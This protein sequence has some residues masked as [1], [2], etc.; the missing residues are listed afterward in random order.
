MVQPKISDFFSSSPSSRLPSQRPMKRQNTPSTAPPNSGTQ[1][2]QSNPF[3]QS[4]QHPQS[5]MPK[6]TR[7]P[8]RS[9]LPTSSQLPPRAASSLPSIPSTPIS[10]AKSSQASKKR[11]AED[12]NE[13]ICETPLRVHKRRVLSQDQHTPDRMS[14]LAQASS[15]CTPFDISSAENSDSDCEI[16]KVQPSPK[17]KRKLVADTSRARPTKKA[18]IEQQPPTQ[19]GYASIKASVLP[20]NAASAAKQKNKPVARQRQAASVPPRAPLPELTLSSLGPSRSNS[21]PPKHIPAQAKKPTQKD[22][23]PQQSTAPESD[24]ESD[25]FIEKVLPSPKRRRQLEQQK[26]NVKRRRVGDSFETS[27]SVDA[28]QADDQD[29]SDCELV[30]VLLSP[31]RQ[32]AAMPTASDSD[33]DDENSQPRPQPGRKIAI[34]RKPQPRS[35]SK[36]TTPATPVAARS[37]TPSRA[38]QSPQI[39][40]TQESSSD[41][42]DFS[43]DETTTAKS[44]APLPAPV[45]NVSGVQNDQALDAG[46][47]ANSN[48]NKP[49]PPPKKSPQTQ[50][51]PRS[52]SGDITDKLMAFLNDRSE[53]LEKEK[54]ASSPSSESNASSNGDVPFSTAPEYPY[55]DSAAKKIKLESHDDDMRFIKQ[56]SSLG[57]HNSDSDEYSG[58][59]ASVDGGMVPIKQESSSRYASS[60]DGDSEEASQDKDLKSI[61]LESGSSSRIPASV[62]HYEPAHDY[63]SEEEYQGLPDLSDD[64]VHI[65]EDKEPEDTDLLPGSKVASAPVA[66]NKHTEPITSTPVS[67]ES[68][69][70]DTEDFKS[71]PPISCQLLL[72]K[73]S[74]KASNSTS[75]DETENESVME[76][77]NDLPGSMKTHPASSVSN[78]Q[79]RLASSLYELQPVYSGERLVESHPHGTPPSFRPHHRES[80]IGLKSILKGSGSKP[81][82][83]SDEET[84]YSPFPDIS[85]LSGDEYII[86]SPSE[87]VQHRTG[88]PLD[89]TPSNDLRHR[90]QRDLN[91]SNKVEKEM[92]PL[93]S[94]IDDTTA[95]DAASNQGTPSKL[96]SKRPSPI[97]Q[98]SAKL[99]EQETSDT[100]ESEDELQ[101]RLEEKQLKPVTN[102]NWVKPPDKEIK[103]LLIRDGVS[104]HAIK[105]TVSRFEQKLAAGKG[106]N[107]N[108]LKYNWDIDWSMPAPL[109]ERASHAVASELRH[110]GI[111][112][113]KQYSNFNYNLMMKYSKLVGSPVPLFSAHKQGLEDF[114]EEAI[115]N[116]ELRKRNGHKKAL[117]AQKRKVKREK[118]NKQPQGVDAFLIP[119]DTD[120]ESK[121]EESDSDGEDLIAKMRADMEKQR[122]SSGGGTSCGSRRT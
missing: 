57:Q 111:K 59:D 75:D 17:P 120:E 104:E 5:T 102:S 70:D 45:Q 118:K 90:C 3:A 58:D 105:P 80:F 114:A 113:D 54:Q 110:R 1:H 38:M 64:E 92:T 60:S 65:F 74:S 37:P 95:D 13:R 31:K 93:K 106:V 15:P 46:R 115:R 83:D 100:E 117:K 98:K 86:S 55:D 39:D 23:T 84:V 87:R 48:T 10:G 35:T 62:K 91:G 2:M 78:F 44:Q 77:L 42:S 96:P 26:A 11:Q 30:K 68:S 19:C 56:E 6:S 9:G 20:A 71:S 85:P 101:K 97:A 14:Q 94:I 108:K 76:G 52:P 24:D 4:P 121:S 103:P 32:G 34:P 40:L 119:G 27:I 79:E 12:R 49:I 61:K 33:A 8:K 88:C 53:A 36:R 99:E 67:Y 72:D 81:G 41:S 47:P 112:T 63:D 28:D 50:E 69:S 25:C 16:Q 29:D 18:K 89:R 66:T 51:Q 82:R 116:E 109:N 107:R 73:T 122:K 21:M 7:K 22:T 43:D